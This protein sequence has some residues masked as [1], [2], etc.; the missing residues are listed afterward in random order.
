MGLKRFLRDRDERWFYSIVIFAVGLLTYSTILIVG[1][2]SNLSSFLLARDSTFLFFAIVALLYLAYRPSG[3]IGTLASFNATLILFASQLS[4]FWLSS[5]SGMSGRYAIGGLLPIYDGSNYYQGARMV[6]EGGRLSVIA[7]WRP[8]FSG[9]FATLLGLTQQ[10]LQLT[11]AILVFINAI[12]GFFL[13]REIQR[14]HGTLAGILVLTLTFLYY[15]NYIGSAMTENLGLGLGAVGLAILWRGAIDERINLCLFG[16]LLL[17]LALNA[18]AGA[19]FILPALILW[20]TWYFRGSSR[21]SAR[22]LLGGISIVLLGFILN[23]VVFKT[24]G[25]PE[26]IANSNFSYSLYG[27]VVGGRWNTVLEHYPQLNSLDEI[28]KSKKVRELALEALRANP[29]GLVTGFFRA[30]QHF[31]FD[32]FVFSFVKSTQINVTLHLLSLL[33][34]ANCYRQRHSPVAS[35]MVA[36]SI[37]TFF[38]VPFVPPWDAGIRP[39]AATI[40]VFS[41]YPAL[42]LNW[43]AQKIKWQKLIRVPPQ[44]KQPRVLLIFGLGLILLSTQGPIATKILS[45]PSQLGDLSCP[46]G[47]TLVYFRYSAGSSINLLTDDAIARSYAPNLRI[48]DFRDGLR[49][50]LNSPDRN[51]SEFAKILAKLPPNSTLSNQ[52]NLQNGAIVWAIAPTNLLPKRFG[53]VGACGKLIS[54]PVLRKQELSFFYA[55]SITLLSER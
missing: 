39:Y 13:A 55:D 36:A 42:G 34:I 20:G 50:F 31:F 18:R 46:V 29:F 10:N 5:I 53:L 32:N 7:S 25:F 8:L 35:L 3:S 17:T 6:L 44:N 48:G 23:S 49:R 27:L 19:F 16:I 12:A 52:I 33:A 26:A 45:H 37:G 21:F 11:V 2:P 41:L 51:M 38:S 14:S 30:W 15:R 24:I 1:I 4:A 9:T 28:E 47:T 22:F 40:P 43:V 54:K